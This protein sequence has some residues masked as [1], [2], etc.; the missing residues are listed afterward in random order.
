MNIYDFCV[1]YS[2]GDLV[3]GCAELKGVVHLK[4][5]DQP[6]LALNIF[7]FEPQSIRALQAFGAKVVRGSKF[8]LANVN[9]NFVGG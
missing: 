6:K 4:M 8:L 1:A 9:I 5:T 7:P 2:D 3:V